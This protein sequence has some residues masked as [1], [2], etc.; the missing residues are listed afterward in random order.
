MQERPEK[1]QGNDG[2]GNKPETLVSIPLTNIPLT[3]D[4]S[5]EMA[6]RESCRK[7]VMLTDCQS[8]YGAIPENCAF[9]AKSFFLCFLCLLLFKFFCCG[10]PRY[11]NV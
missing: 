2:Q 6:G 3:S 9:L 11:E 10:L 4:L 8:F 5:R 7:C 1:C